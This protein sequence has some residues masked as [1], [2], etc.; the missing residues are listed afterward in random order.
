MFERIA[1]AGSAVAAA[2]L[3]LFLVGATPT[4]AQEVRSNT[5]GLILGINLNASSLNVEDGQTESGGGA[6]LLVGWGVSRQ[7]ALFLRGDGAEID[8]SNPD[9]PGSYTY[10]IADLGVRVS[11]GGP[12]RRFIPYLLA[13]LSGQVAS[14]DIQVT[15][16]L[17][18][19][20][21]I[22][23]A[24]LTIG[25]GFNHFFNPKLALDVQLLLTGGEFNEVKVGSLSTGIESL[26]S[27]SAR[28]NVG[29]TWY[30]TS[31]R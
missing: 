24:G 6:G 22:S 1:R 10:A 12:E 29:L 8:I 14:A 7:V 3:L 13:A 11:F 21:E 4:P 28:V 19:D 23:G 20:V 9:I 25:G 26:R 16:V 27:T 31:Q 17:S 18:T 15:P 5:R 30:P 2:A